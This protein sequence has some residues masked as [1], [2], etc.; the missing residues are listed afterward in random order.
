MNDVINTSATAIESSEMTD[1]ILGRPLGFLVGEDRFCLYPVTLGKMLT[2]RYYY[3]S[4][5]MRALSISSHPEADL[6][7]LVHEKKDL[8]AETLVI[9]R[10]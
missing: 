10:R 7:V 9:H 3:D 6:L 4:L 2:L 5:N 1:I 8:C